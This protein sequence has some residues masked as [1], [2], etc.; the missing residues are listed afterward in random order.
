MGEI[1]LID[2][3]ALLGLAHSTVGQ[4]Y[5]A[6]SN[7][8][9][10]TEAVEAELRGPRKRDPETSSEASRVA[11]L[12]DRNDAVEAVGQDRV[13][14]TDGEYG[15]GEQSIKDYIIFGNRDVAAVFFF[16]DDV[17]GIIEDL[18]DRTDFFVVSKIVSFSTFGLDRD[19][20]IE[21]VLKI[22][23]GRGWTSRRNLYDLLVETRIV[24]RTEFDYGNLLFRLEDISTDL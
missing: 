14:S 5:L 10:L 15:Y 16:D 20:Q 8:L 21:E 4:K 3:D 23:K 7:K 24:S 17:E 2:T 6:G 12:L 19:R 18:S 9:R 13:D 11:S 22:A 1:F